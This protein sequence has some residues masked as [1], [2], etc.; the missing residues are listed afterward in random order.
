MADAAAMLR[1]TGCHGVSIG[2]GALANPWI[3]RQLVEWESTGTFGPAGT[4]DD[5]LELM[6]RQFHYLAERVSA[7]SAIH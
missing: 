3:F 5:R 7:E 2:R 4:F 1:E 6:Q